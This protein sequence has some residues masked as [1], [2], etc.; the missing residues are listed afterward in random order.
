MKIV[1][2]VGARPQFVKA[3]IISNLI[4]KHNY[5]DEVLIHTGQH[6]DGNMSEIFFNEMKIPHP[7]YNLNIKTFVIN[8]GGYVSMKKWQGDFFKGN[9]FMF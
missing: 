8:N 7:D 4:K 5:I 3:S 9:I 1:T 2:I 6:F